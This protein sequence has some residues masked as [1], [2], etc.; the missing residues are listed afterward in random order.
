MLAMQIGLLANRAGVAVDTVRYYERVGLLPRP[1]RQPSGYRRYEEEDVLRLRFIRKGKQLGFSLDEIRD[2]LALSS[3]RD[4]DMAGAKTAAEA[5]LQA[6]DAR[7]VELERVRS[8]LRTV[9]DSCPGHGAPSACPIL[10]AL[11]GD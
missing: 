9:A 1:T 4:S 7:I 8:A 6:I 10:A 5:R 2:L 3:S 11:A